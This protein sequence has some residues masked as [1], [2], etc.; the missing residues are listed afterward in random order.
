MS[1]LNGLS[2]D[3]EDWFQVENLKEAISRNDWESCDLRVVQNT[4]RILYLLD[5]Y[6]TRATFFILGWVAEKCPTLVEEI[7]KAGHEIASHGYGHELIYKLTPEEFYKDILRSKEIL[8]SISGRPVCGYRAPSFSIVPE[9]KWA[10]D[11][12]KDVGFLYDSS[13]FP[14]SFHNRYGFN[15][16]SSLPFCFDN[17]LVEMPLSTYRFFGANF[18]VGG[19]GYFRLLPYFFSYL[20]LRGLNSQG[21]A[22]IF[23]LH[24]WELDS[25]QPRVKIRFNYRLRHYIN[26]EKTEFRLEK[27]LKDFKFVNL[28]DL[29]NQYFPKAAQS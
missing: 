2:F 16:T 13:I 7:A 3:I 11:I 28:I 24:P 26:L 20:F 9:S 18:P 12:L 19:G 29:V 4:R 10:L 27:L 6:Q 14:T 21:K 17:G 1:I 25:S 22:I 8:E 15:G 5:Q 23:Y